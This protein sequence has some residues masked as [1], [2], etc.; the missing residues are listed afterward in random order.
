MKRSLLLLFILAVLIGVQFAV[1]FIKHDI[2]SVVIASV[3]TVNE[4]LYI[5]KLSKGE[6]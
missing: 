6:L 4:L 3:L 5:N 2:I 1:G